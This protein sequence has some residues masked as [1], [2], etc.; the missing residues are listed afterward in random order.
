MYYTIPVYEIL[1]SCFLFPCGEIRSFVF[2]LTLFVTGTQKV[3]TRI[4]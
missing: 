2:H 1:V 3:E 4:L